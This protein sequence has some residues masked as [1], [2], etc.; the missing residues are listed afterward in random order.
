MN[1]DEVRHIATE[2]AKE[3]IRE[4]LVAMG[5]NAH[6]EKALLEMQQDF[7]H[8][9]AWRKSTETIKAKS[10]SAAVTFLVTGAFGYLVFLFT[11]HK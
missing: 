2:A 3:A 4:L 9:R 6:D 7:A 8:V 10:L 1:P 5:V 11:T